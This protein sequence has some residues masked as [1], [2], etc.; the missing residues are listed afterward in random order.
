M[1]TAYCKKLRIQRK[2]PSCLVERIYLSINGEQINNVLNTFINIY[3]SLYQP[4]VEDNNFQESIQYTFHI[5]NLS[6]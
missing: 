6:P 4:R 2:N 5:Y 1:F 3:V